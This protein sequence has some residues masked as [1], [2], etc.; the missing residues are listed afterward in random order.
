MRQVYYQKASELYNQENSIYPIFKKMTGNLALIAV[1]PACIILILGENI[2]SFVLGNSWGEAGIYASIITL[3]QYF[4]FINR[5]SIASLLIL[6][7]NHIQLIMDSIALIFRL[8]A[9]L[10]GALVFKDIY[11][12]LGLFTLVG[13]MFN[14]FLISYVYLKLREEYLKK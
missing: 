12:T 4:G 1:L 13:I 3:W 2:F 6:K 8:I 14:L 7:L 10:V 9:I 11:I 5:P